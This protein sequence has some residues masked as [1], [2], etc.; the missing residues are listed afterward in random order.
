M[1]PSCQ[2]VRRQ[3]SV[4]INASFE[5]SPDGGI[6][7]P[8]V[9]ETKEKKGTDLFLF[10]LGPSCLETVEGQPLVLDKTPI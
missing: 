8:Q 2:G 3:K 9:K 5:A 6:S 7:D 4:K 1:V 10:L